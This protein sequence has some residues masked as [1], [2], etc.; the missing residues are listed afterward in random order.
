MKSNLTLIL[1]INCA[2]PAYT[3]AAGFCVVFVFAFFVSVNFIAVLAN[4][5]IGITILAVQKRFKKLRRR[6]RIKK[7]YTD[8]FSVRRRRIFRGTGADAQQG[9]QLRLDRRYNI[10]NRNL[11]SWKCWIPAAKTFYRRF[12]LGK[13]SYE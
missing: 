1:K 5:I 4:E 6:S 10:Q 9:R 13:I 7:N 11:L 8:C 2:L 12:R 3:F